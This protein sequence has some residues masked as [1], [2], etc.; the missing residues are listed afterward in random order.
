[1]IKR[2][3][4]LLLAVFILG[5]IA[6]ICL[7]AKNFYV[8][9]RLLSAGKPATATVLD[10]SAYKVW[11]ESKGYQITVSFETEDRQQ[12]TNT[13][14]VPLDLYNRAAQGTIKVFY[15]PGSPS[16]CM[17]G[18]S[19]QLQYGQ[20]A[21][22]CFFMVAGVVLFYVFKRFDWSSLDPEAMVEKEC[23]PIAVE[24]AQRITKQMET[25]TQ[26][27]HVYAP[28]NPREFPHLDLAFYDQSR[29]FLESKGFQ[30]L[31]DVENLTVRSRS[32]APRTFS[33]KLLAGDGTMLAWLYHFI[34]PLA[35]RAKGAKEMKVLDL[36][37]QFEN[38]CFVTTSNA[39]SVG[40]LSQ[41]PQ[42]QGL[43]MAAGTSQEVLLETHKKCIAEFATKSGTPPVS[44]KNLEDVQRSSETLQRLKAEYRRQ[45]GLTNDELKRL[46]GVSANDKMVTML[47]EE[48]R[49]GQ[50]TK[51]Q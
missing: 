14:Q 49:K 8:S 30:F 36:Q 46:G 44:L 1:M 39:E 20:L 50:E 16:V 51:G 38:G 6:L 29:A 28:A 11:R 5:G 2:K 13:L 41:P 9:Q 22:G 24:A 12:I 32:S 45:T 37:T 26:S 33:R 17:A 43:Y 31:E 25:L 48:I 10:R 27:K 23:R 7:G 40:K 4:N 47:S 15:L 35:S 21:V 34:P 42:I 19:I 3:K 18:D